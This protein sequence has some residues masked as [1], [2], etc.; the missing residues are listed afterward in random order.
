MSDSVNTYEGMFLV[1]AGSD[2]NAASAP[3]RTVLERSDAEL[4][5]IKPWEERRLAYPING[6]RRGLYVLVYFKADPL[7]VVEI[8]RDT[9][10]SEEILRA[11]ILHNDNVSEADI[12]A[13]TPA[14]QGPRRS[15]DED[16]SRR[17]GGGRSSRGVSSRGESSRGESR[18]GDA[19]QSARPSSGGSASSETRAEARKTE[20]DAPPA[21]DET[22]GGSTGGEASADK[23]AGEQG[24]SGDENASS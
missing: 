16:D 7:K 5:A 17:D 21:S 23:A 3:V 9:Q 8:E 18:R 14:T 19:G 6:R 20:A 24:P 1:D 2:F 10:L 13:E 22:G 11:L 4:L 15:E 12:A